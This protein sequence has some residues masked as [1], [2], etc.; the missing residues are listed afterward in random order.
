MIDFRL[1]QALQ[2][3]AI[4]YLTTYSSFPNLCFNEETCYSTKSGDGNISQDYSEVNFFF[5]FSILLLGISCQKYPFEVWCKIWKMNTSDIGYRSTVRS[6][7]Y[8]LEKYHVQSCIF[9][10]IHQKISIIAITD[11][12]YVRIPLHIKGLPKLLFS[13]CRPECP[14]VWLFGSVLLFFCNKLKQK[15]D[16]GYLDFCVRIRSNM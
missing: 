16:Y 7:Q 1:D 5:T 8:Q 10:Q 13:N 4:L 3:T 9:E 12:L 6:F 2:N 14:R 11:V 15:F